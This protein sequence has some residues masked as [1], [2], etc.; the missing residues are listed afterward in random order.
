MA[1]R[2]AEDWGF[3]SGEY[4]APAP[5]STLDSGSAIC[6]AIVDGPNEDIDELATVLEDF[7]FNPNT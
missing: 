4:I 5:A 3:V 1:N 6:R 7:L 2:L